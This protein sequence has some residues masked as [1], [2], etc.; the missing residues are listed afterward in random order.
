M[1]GTQLDKPCRGLDVLENYLK[2][3]D[4]LVQNEFSVADVAVASYLNYVPIFFS[5]ANPISRPNII[6]YMKRCA[7][8]SAYGEAFGKEHQELV[9]RKTSGWLEKVSGSGGF[10]MW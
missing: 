8:R 4:W 9:N 5:N 6:K 7:E 1:S 3:K 10:K 2:D